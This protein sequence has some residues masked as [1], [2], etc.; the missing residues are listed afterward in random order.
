MELR[1]A[2][3]SE[4]YYGLNTS[5]F[6]GKEDWYLL[7]VLNSS[8]V[9][10]Y[11]KGTCQLL[12][13]EDDGGRLRFFGQYLET[14]PIPSAKKSECDQIAEMAQRVQGMHLSRRV[15][16]EEFLGQIGV[17]LAQS[18]SRNPLEQPWMLSEIEYLKRTKKKPLGIYEA[19]KR[20]TNRLTETIVALEEAIDTKV[21]KLYGVNL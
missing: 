8:P 18:T 5:Y 14:L 20:D 17:D 7:G 11:L 15:R 16:V 1:F 21:S 2:M 6:I 12:G 3:D 19:A 13:D 10:Q 4:S 9:F